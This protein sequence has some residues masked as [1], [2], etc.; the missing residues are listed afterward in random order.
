MRIL[1]ANKFYYRR[2]GDCIAML[3]LEQLLKEQG[4]EVAVFAMDY[5]DNLPTPWQKYF[6]K[7]IK[8]IAGP[9]MFETMK[10]TFGIGQVRNNF[11]HLLN[12]FK[13]DVVH[14]HNIHTQLSPVLA[15]LAHQRGIKVVWTMHDFKLLCPRYDCLRHGTTI[16]EDCFTDKHKVLEYKCMKGSRIA[17]LVAYEEAIKWNK[18]RLMA[19]TD[20]FI[21][22]S[23][24]M[25]E[26][27]LQG[28]FNADKIVVLP[29]FI[30]V[31]KCHIP[32][33]ISRAEYYCYVGRL[34]HEKGIATLI[35]AAS[36]LPYR[37][38]IVGDG[39][40]RNDLESKAPDNVEF[41]GYKGWEEIKDIVAKAK[42]MVIPS[43]WYENNPL[44]VIESLS[45]GT[46]VLGA[47]IGGIPELIREDIS[48][49]TFESGNASDLAEKIKLMWTAP[50]DYKSIAE[51]AKRKYNAAAYYEK[52]MDL[53]K[54]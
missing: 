3:N 50:F 36:R 26:K 8:F 42:F 35:D 39:P 24:F 20:I 2:G 28:G 45:L 9:G 16:C 25:G 22:P 11:M 27:M 49:M 37:L 31:E 4:H 52:Y 1:L 17:S 51:D 33:A 5:P 54:M 40:M 18:D 48:G 13:P 12:D 32:G 34:S 41:V 23:A 46:P 43:E 30:D 10:R 38:I 44:S 6:P 14:L 47:K 21:C 7:E 53:L 19:S 29:N 15:E